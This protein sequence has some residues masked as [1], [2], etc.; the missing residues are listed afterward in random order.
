M[1][2]HVNLNPVKAP[3]QPPRTLHV[4]CAVFRFFSKL[5][6]LEARHNHKQQCIKCLLARLSLTY[7]LACAVSFGACN[8]LRQNGGHRHIAESER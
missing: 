5:G 1:V 8:Q 3:I 2:R 7:F 4:H 6:T